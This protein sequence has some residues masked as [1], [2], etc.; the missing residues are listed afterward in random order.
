MMKPFSFVAAALLLA[1]AFSTSISASPQSHAVQ[2]QSSQ[3]VG[4]AGG[5]RVVELQDL[6][7]STTLTALVGSDHADLA[8]TPTLQDSDTCF[9]NATCAPSGCAPSPLSTESC[10]NCT[11]LSPICCQGLFSDC[12]QALDNCCPS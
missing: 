1:L 3:A 8:A 6:Q 11:V 4:T 9:A 5:D 7:M 2:Q 10:W 12:G